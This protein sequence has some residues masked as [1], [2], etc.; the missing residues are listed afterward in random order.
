M[1]MW[2]LVISDET[3][4]E[5]TSMEPLKLWVSVNEESCVKEKGGCFN[6]INLKHGMTHIVQW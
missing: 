6:M 4:G 1:N 5:T 2:L 3:M